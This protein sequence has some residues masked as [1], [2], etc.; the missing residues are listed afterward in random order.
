[1]IF[2]NASKIAIDGDFSPVHCLK[3][4]SAVVDKNLASD[5][6]TIS[7]KFKFILVKFTKKLRVRNIKN[8]GSQRSRQFWKPET[9]VILVIHEDHIFSDHQDRR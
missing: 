5:F 8:F 2:D 7:R 9:Y 1:M 6:I 4:F 3:G